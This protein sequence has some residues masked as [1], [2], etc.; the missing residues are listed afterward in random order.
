[1]K[2][3]KKI[4]MKCTLEKAKFT[5]LPLIHIPPEASPQ[6]IQLQKLQYLT[7]GPWFLNKIQIHNKLVML[8]EF[9][10]NC[11]SMMM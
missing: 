6:P 9:E 10:K 3:D 1:M 8:K 11:F 4:V 7:L 2:L 5:I